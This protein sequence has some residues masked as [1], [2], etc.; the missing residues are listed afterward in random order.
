MCFGGVSGHSNWTWDNSGLF[1][2]SPNGWEPCADRTNI[3]A[4]LVPSSAQ[5][6]ARPY[7]YAV[8]GEVLSFS[9]NTTSVEA[10]LVFVPSQAALASGA[11][12]QLFVSQSWW[13][14]AGFTVSV[15][16]PG[17]AT[18]ATVSK[19]WLNVTATAQGV[20]QNVTIRL[21]PVTSQL[22]A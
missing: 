15:E 6:Y 14:T 21:T 22:W 9:F 5:F 13:F 1:T 7:P 11:P 20:G 10:E 3:T 12:T 8:A 2:A 17:A 18:W 19:D 4:C 16:P